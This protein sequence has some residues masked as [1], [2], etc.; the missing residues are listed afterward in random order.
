MEFTSKLDFDDDIALL[1]SNR[2]QTPTKTDRVNNIAG[3]TGLKIN[4][5][6]TQVMRV[7]PTSNAHSEWERSGG[8]IP[9]TWPPEGRRKRGRPKEQS[10]EKERNNCLQAGVKQQELQYR[11]TW[12]MRVPSSIVQEERT[13]EVN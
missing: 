6:K 11:N 1:S 7:H 2:Q 4:I 9:M 13:N 12:K 5:S 3:S 10:K 8:R